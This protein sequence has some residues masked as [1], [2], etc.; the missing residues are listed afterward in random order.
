MK[1]LIQFI[2]PSGLQSQ[3]LQVL[4]LDITHLKHTVSN[5]EKQHAILQYVDL[6]GD[7]LNLN[8]LLSES[9]VC[10]CKTICISVLS[11]L[12]ASQLYQSFGKV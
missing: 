12:Y 1:V 5:I 3:T 10:K 2:P 7:A 6:V 8:C 11:I 9:Q 4:L